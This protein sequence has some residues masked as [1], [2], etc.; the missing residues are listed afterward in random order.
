MESEGTDMVGTGTDEI[1]PQM[2][3]LIEDLIHVFQSFCD[4]RKV[5]LHNNEPTEDGWPDPSSIHGTDY[6]TLHGD[7]LDVLEGWGFV[8]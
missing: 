4:A 6:E 3:E 2:E 1:D 7:I 8:F 5:D